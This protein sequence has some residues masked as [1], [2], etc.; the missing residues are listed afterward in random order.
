[1][2]DRLAAESSMDTALPGRLHRPRCGL[3]H[4]LRARLS[5]SA[6]RGRGSRTSLLQRLEADVF[7]D[8]SD[9]L[10]DVVDALPTRAVTIEDLPADLMSRPVASDGRARVELFTDAYLNDP[11]ELERIASLVH[12]IR[13]DAGG[14]VPGAVELGRAMVS[15]LR[16]ALITAVV[17][18]ARGSSYCGEASD[19]RSRLSHYSRSEASV[20]PR[21]RSWLM[22]P[23]ASQT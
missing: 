8:L 7:N 2:R 5:G 4:S 6:R 17:V 21:W 11:G 14:P 16:D 13:P 10:E 12:A 23:S 19:T 15:S 9:V 22:S 18:I 20:R 1:M 3:R